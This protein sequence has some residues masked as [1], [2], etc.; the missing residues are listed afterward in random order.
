M[1]SPHIYAEEYITS[2]KIRIHNS[3]STDIL[4]QQTNIQGFIR[5]MDVHYKNYWAYAPNDWYENCVSSE[6]TN[7]ITISPN[8][9]VDVILKVNEKNACLTKNKA[10]YDVINT[11][12]GEIISKIQMQF[13]STVLCDRGR[14]GEMLCPTENKQ[15]KAATGSAKMSNHSNNTALLY[16]AKNKSNSFEILSLW[17]V[18]NPH[19]MNWQLAAISP[20]SEPFNVEN[21]SNIIAN[22]QYLFAFTNSGYRAG[23]RNEFNQIEWGSDIDLPEQLF[24]YTRSALNQHGQVLL[25]SQDE[26]DRLSYLQGKIDADSIEWQSTNWICVT[27]STIQKE[28]SGSDDD[29]DDGSNVFSGKSPNIAFSKDG[30]TAILIYRQN[31]KIRYHLGNVQEEQVIWS[32]KYTVGLSDVY[33][34]SATFLTNDTVLVAGSTGESTDKTIKFKLGKLDDGQFTWQNKH[35]FYDINGRSAAVLNAEVDPFDSDIHYIYLTYLRNNSKGIPQ[36]YVTLW[37]LSKSTGDIKDEYAKKEVLEKYLG[38]ANSP[39]SLIQ[40]QGSHALSPGTSDFFIASSQDNQLNIHQLPAELVYYAV[41][42]GVTKTNLNYTA[43]HDKRWD[44]AFWQ[45]KKEINSLMINPFCVFD[46]TI[47]QFAIFDKLILESKSVMFNEEIDAQIEMNCA[48]P[49]SMTSKYYFLSLYANVD[50]KSNIISLQDIGS[51]E[52]EATLQNTPLLNGESLSFNIITQGFRNFPA[53]AADQDSLSSGTSI[54]FIPADFTDPY[55]GMPIPFQRDDTVDSMTYSSDS[56]RTALSIDDLAMISERIYSSGE[57]YTT[58][59]WKLE[60]PLILERDENNTLVTHQAAMDMRTYYWNDLGLIHGASPFLFDSVTVEAVEV[61]PN[62]IER[63]IISKA[64]THLYGQIIFDPV[65]DF[66]ATISDFNIP[67]EGEFNYSIDK[68]ASS[69]HKDGALLG[70]TANLDSGGW[71]FER[72]GQDETFPLTL[73]SGAHWGGINITLLQLYE[74]KL[75]QVIMY[76]TDNNTFEG[77]GILTIETSGYEG[78]STQTLN[79]L[80][81]VNY[82]DSHLL[83]VNISAKNFSASMPLIDIESGV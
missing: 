59:D 4:I 5:A 70:S 75:N 68:S 6:T 79:V 73:A 78:V 16:T 60:V 25:I 28:C 65:L 34:P 40:A 46:D 39:L 11:S 43:N 14:Y 33:Q 48:K 50:L 77:H 29:S 17:D 30:K 35:N 49:L 74:F 32:D 80:V 37:K 56:N 3:A 21:T 82:L 62:I 51:D 61:E 64:D 18:S 26:D 9:S 1:L 55:F 54:P 15:K 63:L 42:T 2:K 72:F 44:L 38:F 81:V 76:P 20:L 69:T 41:A 45:R 8:Q 24:L 31:G 57:N 36:S 52:T 12:T 7:N 71:S 83:S 23:L 10:W 67:L 13:V 47:D 66:N 19:L 58:R 27:T 53:E 22:N